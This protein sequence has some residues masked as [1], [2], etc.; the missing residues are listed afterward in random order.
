MIRRFSIGLAGGKLLVRLSLLGGVGMAPALAAI[1][2]EVLQRVEI[3]RVAAEVEFPSIEL[4]DGRRVQL[5]QPVV[6]PELPVPQRGAKLS[7]VAG[8]IPLEQFTRQSLQAPVMIEIEPIKD[9]SGERQAHRIRSAFIVH[10]SLES[11]RNEQLLEQAIG[12]GGG[13]A[14]AERSR[15]VPPEVLDQLGIQPPGEDEQYL[16]VT[17]PLLNEVVVQ[18]T[19]RAVKQEGPNWIRLAWMLDPRFDGVEDYAGRWTK[20]VRDDLGGLQRTR[21][22]AYSG[23]GGVTTVV[24]TDGDSQQLLLESRMILH[25]PAEWFVGSNFL[26]AKLPLA[27]QESARNLRRELSR[28]K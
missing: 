18:G 23:M 19:L 4:P 24:V 21:P 1:G 10:A 6:S 26:R 12:K 3:A 15:A 28:G 2:Q 5:E 25:E 13:D 20:E 22:A 16:F 17:F 9:A 27:I 11:L 7:E 8:R 14:A